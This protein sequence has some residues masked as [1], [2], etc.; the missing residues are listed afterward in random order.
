MQIVKPEVSAD[1][2]EALTGHAEEVLKRLKL[3][4]RRVLLCAGDTW[5]SFGENL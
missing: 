4:F 3:P 1:A 5:V 2:L